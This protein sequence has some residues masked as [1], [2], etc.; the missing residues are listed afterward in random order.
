MVGPQ[1]SQRLLSGRR[2]GGT[3]AASGRELLHRPSKN[4]RSCSAHLYRASS[5]RFREY[6]GHTAF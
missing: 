6:T 4:R 1:V 2:L 3:S 5:G